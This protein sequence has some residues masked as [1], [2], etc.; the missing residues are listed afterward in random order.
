LEKLAKQDEA[1]VKVH[2]TASHRSVQKV[3]DDR[4]RRAHGKQAKGA[5]ERG[6]VYKV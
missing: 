1:E 6:K 4:S 3:V 2:W 5:N